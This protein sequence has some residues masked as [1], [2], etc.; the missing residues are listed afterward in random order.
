MSIIPDEFR[1]SVD[2]P[3]WDTLRTLI[4][5]AKSLGYPKGVIREVCERAIKN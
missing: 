2:I 3:L 4:A 1:H 5:L